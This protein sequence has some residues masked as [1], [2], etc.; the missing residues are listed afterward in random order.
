LEEHYLL[1]SSLSIVNMSGDEADGPE[2]RLK[3]V[4]VIIEAEWQSEDIKIFFRTLDKRYI[5]DWMQ[6]LRNRGGRGPRLRVEKDD[7]E[8]MDSEAPKRL[9]RNCYSDK[10][11]ASKPA[12]FVRDLEIIDE[13]YDFRID[14]SKGTV[15]LQEAKEVHDV[16][17]KNAG[18]DN[19]EE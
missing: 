11:L 9:W 2:G 10:W 5:E 16:F 6:G 17:M 12:W 7:A 15:P 1:F 4:Y 8:V 18:I 13:D 14:F 3:S 19:P